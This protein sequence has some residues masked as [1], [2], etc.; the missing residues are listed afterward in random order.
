MPRTSR[1]SIKDRKEILARKDPAGPTYKDERVPNIPPSPPRTPHSTTWTMV[2]ISA[3]IFSLFAAVFLRPASFV[4][5]NNVPNQAQRVYAS[6]FAVLDTV[7]PVSQAN[8]STVR[9]S[10]QDGNP[11]NQEERLTIAIHF[12]RIF[13]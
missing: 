8:I 11:R 6:A 12:A 2:Y 1:L 9:H 5:A 3:A 13:A 10:E 7:P 4:K